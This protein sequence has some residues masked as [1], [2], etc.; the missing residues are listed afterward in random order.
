MPVGVSESNDI[1]RAGRAETTGLVL[2]IW[3]A[4]FRIAR[5]HT[6]ILVHS[7]TP[8][9]LCECHPL[10]RAVGGKPYQVQCTL[11]NQSKFMDCLF[12]STFRHFV[13]LIYVPVKRDYKE[14]YLLVTIVS[15]KRKRL[16]NI[17]SNIV[18]FIKWNKYN[19]INNKKCTRK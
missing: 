3:T 15:L 4:T 13:S 2:D 10:E 17:L 16:S 8:T 7:P 9:N 19:K 5:I 6:R 18:S 14:L 12:Y 1:V 11:F